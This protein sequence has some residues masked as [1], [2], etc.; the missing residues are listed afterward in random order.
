M[1]GYGKSEESFESRKY[2]IEMRSVNNRFCEISF[3]YPKY[4]FTKDLE[5]KEIIKQRI[6]R[7]KINVSINIEN[8][9]NN[10]LNLE[11]NKDA[12][13]G[14]LKILKSLKKSIGS[15]EKVKLDHLLDFSD[16]FTSTQSREVNKNEYAF[17]C[18]LLNEAIDD[19]MEM[20]VKEGDY[21]KDDMLNRINLID[22]EIKII[23]ELGKKRIPEEKKILKEKVDS[24]LEDRSIVDDKRL[25]LEFT[26][27]AD[28][29]DITEECIRLG[30]HI[31]YF[32]ECIDSDKQTG[33][34]LNFLLQEMNREI[35]TISSKI[36]DSNISQKVTIMKEELE[37]I[38]EQIQNVE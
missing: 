31:Q 11:V 22:K 8:G 14:Y 10:D 12:V 4:L 13:K 3:K 33:R 2:T 5:L 27:L 32:K 7:G 34:R 37:K 25:E 9:I 15:K 20:K 17:I 29:L 30:S 35:N 23:T 21:L 28:K 6:T 26:L 1:T 24:L 38:R 36:L 19:L 16:V 18:N